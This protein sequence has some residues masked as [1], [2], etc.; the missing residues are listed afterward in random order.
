[1][2]CS[3]SIAP[4]VH[5]ASSDPDI[6]NFVASDPNSTSLRAPLIGSDGKPVPSDTSGLFCAY[7]AGTTTVSIQAGGLS[8]STKVTI[9]GG[10][11]KRP[12]GTVPLSPSRFPKPVQVSIVPA[13]PSAPAAAATPPASSHHTTPPPPPPSAPVPPSPAPAKVPAPKPPPAKVPAPAPHPAPPAPRPA[14]R[15]VVPVPPKPTVAVP[16]HAIPPPNPTVAR[17][18]PPAGTAQVQ[19]PVQVSAFGNVPAA[20]EERREEV[21]PEDV[22]AAAAY[23]PGSP[24]PL[25]PL[26]LG[27]VVIAAAAGSGLRR[28]RG[29]GREVR[30]A[31]VWLDDR[32]GRLDNRG[33]PPRRR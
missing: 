27:V 2:G 3:T 30:P 29:G 11:P 8:Y 12:C 25:V 23:H 13:P 16:P 6:G 33:R 9:T 1:V 10:S 17:P 19:N 20:R 21:A 14:P 15:P 22:Q 24:A 31:P 28:G 32:G 5:F 26:M 7:N 4:E 18:I